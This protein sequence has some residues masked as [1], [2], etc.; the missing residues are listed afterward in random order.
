MTSINCE[1]DQLQYPDKWQEQIIDRLL[2]NISKEAQQRLTVKVYGLTESLELKAKPTELISELKCKIQQKTGIALQ[3]K[4][5]CCIV[6]AVWSIV[7][8]CVIAV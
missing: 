8:W 5:V 2:H 1:L 6:I 3:C 4:A 7:V